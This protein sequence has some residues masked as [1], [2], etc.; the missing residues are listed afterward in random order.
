MHNP[1]AID[2]SDVG[3]LIGALELNGVS[4]ARHDGALEAS[5]LAVPPITM[6]PCPMRID[7]GALEASV[8]VA[9]PTINFPC[10][11]ID[12]D[13]LEAA[14]TAAGPTAIP[15]PPF[16][17]VNDDGTLEATAHGAPVTLFPCPHRIDDGA[18]EATAHGARP[19]TAFPC[20]M[21]IDDG[22]N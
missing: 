19:F 11:R 6:F 13:A 8:T 1:I 18:L 7:D 4:S 15:R 16:C 21:G 5:A 2:A 22:A 9:G 3:R 14:V 17:I 12:D 10:R 20:P